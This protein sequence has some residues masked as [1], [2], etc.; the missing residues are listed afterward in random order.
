M[1]CRVF[2]VIVSLGLFLIC[3]SVSSRELTVKDFASLPDVQQVELSPDGNRLVYVASAESK[4]SQGV[5][6]N[7]FDFSKRKL[8]QLLYGDSD[9][10][11]V[12]DVSWANDEHIFVSA[13]FPTMRYGT[14]ATESRLLI[15]DVETSKY[16]NV[17]SNGALK[18]FGNFP[19]YRDRIVDRLPLDSEHFLLQVDGVSVNEPT[20]YKVSINKRKMRI[21]NKH[22]KNVT[23]WVTDTNGDVRIGIYFKD[24]HYKIIHSFPG[25]DD[26][27]TLWE[28]DSFSDEEVWPIGFSN[29]SDVLYVKALH[30][31]RDA[32]FTVNLNDE[33]L[34]KN[35]IY[36]DEYYDIDGSLFYSRKTGKA[37]GLNL[38][39]GGGYIFWDTSYAALMGGIDS[40]LPDTENHLIGFSRDERKYL[41]LTTSDVESGTYYLGDRDRGTLDPVAYRYENLLPALLS[42]KE[43]V[44]YRA[45]DGVNIEGYLTLPKSHRKGDRHP[46]VIFPHGGPI[47][48]DGRGFD[49]W[50]QFFAYSGY[51]V[52][53]MNFRGSSGYGYDFMASGLK[54]WGLAMQD[55]VDDGTRWMISK[56]YSDPSK[57]CVVGASYGGYAALMSAL[58]SDDLYRCAV[59]FAGVSSLSS[60]VKSKWNYTNYDELKELVGSDY[61]ALKKRSPLYYA[62]EIDVPILLLHGTKDR[63][64]K[65]N[66]S[67]RMYKALRREKKDVTYIEL[68]DGN[69]Y[70][71]KN[72]NRIK[73]FEAMDLFLKRHLGIL[74]N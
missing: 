44:S 48:H 43:V 47:S 2:F 3:G 41:V 64:V 19:Q 33:S 4:D 42:K 5:V 30:E 25:S 53:Q 28:F 38:S 20:V 9:D 23:E 58:K 67:V 37:V 52:L 8:D 54:S 7:V 1:L 10:F 68:E 36:F 69:H 45:R 51:A 59:S 63:K 46:T 40:A 12:G 26:W 57:I 13:I 15:V 27:K 49:Y 39:S 62:N 55:D 6:I 60:F 31:G 35:L 70:L 66:Q 18:K 34:V 56:G 65:V 74:E 21:V 61:K 32:I 71:S 17:I 29:D 16:R 72:E 24:T 50:T 22:Q 14:P 73:S 11:V